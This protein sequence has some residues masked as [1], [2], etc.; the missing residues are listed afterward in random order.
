M[1]KNCPC[2]AG[3][4]NVI[5]KEDR[6]YV[7]VLEALSEQEK[8]VSDHATFSSSNTGLSGRNDDQHQASLLSL[9]QEAG[10]VPYPQ[11][12]RSRT[13]SQNP[14]WTQNGI[15]VLR[16]GRLLVPRKGLRRRW[17]SAQSEERL[18]MFSCPFSLDDQLTTPVVMND[19]NPSGATAPN[20]STPANDRTWRYLHRGTVDVFADAV[21][22]L[23]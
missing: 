9:G 8:L 5:E 17:R 11:F 3:S 6:K 19:F 22:A 4:T 15:A 16:L 21:S 18:S 12:T 20:S 1:S 13:F 2:E 14:P 10:N 7:R 23:R